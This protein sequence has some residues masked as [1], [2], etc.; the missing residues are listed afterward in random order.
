MTASGFKLLARVLL[1]LGGVGYITPQ[2]LVTPIMSIGVGPI[3]VRFLIGIV[4]VVLGLYFII[5]K[6]P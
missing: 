6:V 5:K 1:V 2:I 3:T 4:S